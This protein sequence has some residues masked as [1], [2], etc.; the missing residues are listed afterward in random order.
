MENIAEQILEQVEP[1][2]GLQIS[3][4]QRAMDMGC[5]GFGEIRVLENKH[6]AEY[7]LHVQCPWRIESEDGIIT[8][9]RDIWDPPEEFA[10]KEEFESWKYDNG[11]L[12]DL[13]IKELLRDDDPQLRI[14]VNKTQKLFVEQIRADHYGGLNINLTGGYRLVLFPAGSRG[15]D[16]RFF[17]PKN[18]KSHFVISGGRIDEDGCC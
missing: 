2:I 6:V 7:A 11:N 17:I 13:R 5:F 15:E 9:R 8:G 16:W 3:Y 10:S 18:K 4:I 12:Q 14:S 1:L